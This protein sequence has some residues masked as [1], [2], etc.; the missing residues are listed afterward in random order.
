MTITIDLGP[1]VLA[2]LARQAAAHGRSVEAHAAHVLADAVQLPA[3]R[4]GIEI[5]DSPIAV[6]TLAVDRTRYVVARPLAFS[7]AFDPAEGV[8]TATGDFHMMV[9]AE[10]RGELEHVVQQAL[11]FL[12]DEYAMADPGTL[13][14]DALA[15]REQL[16]ATFAESADAA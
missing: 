16:I 4:D 1:E 7:V 9:C 5:N 14:G 15:L 6:T 11:V 8:Y 2:A 10:T 13:S 3:D 12:W